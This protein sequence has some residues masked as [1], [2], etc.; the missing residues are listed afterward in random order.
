VNR[1]LPLAAAM[2]AVPAFTFFAACSGA[3]LPVAENNPPGP[4]SGGSTTPD[5]G[6]GS[7]DG[8]TPD[9]GEK[10]SSTTDGGGS[11]CSPA[12]K[13]GDVCVSDQVIGGAFITPDD[14]GA[15]PPGRHVEGIRCEN[16]PT[17]H[18]VTSPPSCAGGAID[19]TCASTV[20]SSQSSCPYLC[21]S[22]TS[23]QINCVC[24][25]P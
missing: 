19:C 10:D 3:T 6:G 14:A 17:Y 5:G 9:G 25:V 21:Q 16:D 11:G 20:C 2:L 1:F 23:T 15:C 13:S 22:A 4:D 24:P 12:C 8:A 18:C 7:P